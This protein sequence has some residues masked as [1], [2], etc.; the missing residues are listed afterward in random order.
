MDELWGGP[1]PLDPPL[2]YATG[3]YYLNYVLQRIHRLLHQ[4]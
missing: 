1:D 4:R 3:T 2:I